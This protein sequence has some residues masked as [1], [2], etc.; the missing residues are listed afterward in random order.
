MFFELGDKS[1]G[2]TVAA[3]VV[4]AGKIVTIE[5]LAMKLPRKQWEKYEI[6]PDQTC[7]HDDYSRHILYITRIYFHY[8]TPEIELIGMKYMPLSIAYGHFTAPNDVN[9]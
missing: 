3:A 2:Y 6:N 4:C 8:G 5:T 7:F 9:V 1:N